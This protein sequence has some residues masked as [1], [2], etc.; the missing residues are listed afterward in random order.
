FE[1]LVRWYPLA[2]V[3]YGA[4]VMV[5]HRVGRDDPEPARGD[6]AGEPPASREVEAPEDPM[7]PLPLRTGEGIRLLHPEEVEWIE[8]DGNYVVVHCG[9]GAHRARGRISELESSLEEDGF[10]RVHRSALVRVACIRELR[11]LSHGDMEVVLA[12]G[13]TLRLSR[14]RRAELE[15]RLGVEL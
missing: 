8:A 5:G 7:A 15:E 11:P 6:G 13:K 14:G 12:G 2:L 4:I 9:D 10:A 3:V 1:G